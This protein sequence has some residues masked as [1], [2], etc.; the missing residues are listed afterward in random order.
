MEALIL[1]DVFP[2]AADDDGATQQ[3]LQQSR[4]LLNRL[5]E[6]RVQ[7]RQFLERA[8]AQL[9]GAREAL[10][11]SPEAFLLVDPKRDV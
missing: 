4:A 7:T 3:S 10:R 9:D 11:H 8:L 2:H 1:I 6:G 5:R